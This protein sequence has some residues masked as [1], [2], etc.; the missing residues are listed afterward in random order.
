MLLLLNQR[1]CEKRQFI[2]ITT[3]H[4]NIEILA[5]YGIQAHFLKLS[6]MSKILLQLSS[7][8]FLFYRLLKKIH[9]VNP[10]DKYLSKHDTDL[11]YFISPSIY[12]R[13]T[14]KYNYI[15]T[16]WDLCHRDFMEFPEVR[17][18]RIFE[19]REAVY[20]HALTKAFAL[21]DDI[22]YYSMLIRKDGRFWNQYLI[23]FQ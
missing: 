13:Y 1:Q 3:L 15:F 6:L 18:N 2:F 20:Q 19:S 21:K 12:A 8:H 14:D 16:V 10:F 11:I 17:K 7:Q 4:S 5:T 22:S 9:I 23:D